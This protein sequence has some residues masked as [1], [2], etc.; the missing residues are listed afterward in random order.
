MFY[1]CKNGKLLVLSE[2]NRHKD[3]K[4]IL[5][6]GLLINIPIL[7]VN[8]RC[9]PL[10]IPEYKQLTNKQRYTYVRKRQIRPFF[11]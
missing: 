7:T 11:P 2:V 5:P 1:R 9:I 10:Q 8:F 4:A 6:F 3:Q